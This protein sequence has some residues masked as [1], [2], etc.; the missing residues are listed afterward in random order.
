MGDGDGGMLATAVGVATAAM[1]TMVAIVVRE[2][3]MTAASGGWKDGD[4]DVGCNG[5][6]WGRWQQQQQR[7]GANCGGAE[8][9]ATR[10]RWQQ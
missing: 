3:A 10:R 4:G 7:R 8:L 1:A 9:M 5:G 6:N 2:I